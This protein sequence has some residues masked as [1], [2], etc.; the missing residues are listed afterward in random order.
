MVCVQG[1]QR[2]VPS[3]VTGVV[4]GG[5]WLVYEGVSEGMVGGR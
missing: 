5:W 3:R 2:R 1:C 4:R